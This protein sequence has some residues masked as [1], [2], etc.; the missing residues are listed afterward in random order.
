MRK[1]YD[2]TVSA[3]SKTLAEDIISSINDKMTVK[4][5]SLGVITR[6]NGVNITQ[7]RNFIKVHNKTYIEKILNDK[8][9]F[10]TTIAGQHSPQYIPMHNNTE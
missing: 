4:I 3:P 8:N 2:F 10:H 6:F 5:K 1:V 9:W 7:T